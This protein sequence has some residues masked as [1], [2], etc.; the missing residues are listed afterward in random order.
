MELAV[1]ARGGGHVARPLHGT[2]GSKACRQIGR[3]D[4]AQPD[5]DLVCSGGIIALPPPGCHLRE[6]GPGVGKQPL[7]D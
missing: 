6:M 3:V 4:S 1:S 5:D 2:R 7:T